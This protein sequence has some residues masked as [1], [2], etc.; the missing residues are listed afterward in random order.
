M[1]AYGVS[2]K[3]SRQ[4][5]PRDGRISTNRGANIEFS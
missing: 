5:G 4:K 3:I 2:Q 1:S